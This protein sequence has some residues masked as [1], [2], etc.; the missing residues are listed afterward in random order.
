MR[1]RGNPITLILVVL[2]FATAVL[3]VSEA[4]GQADTL[5]VIQR[6]LLNIPA[7]VRPGDALSIQCQSSG[8][9]SGW[10]ATMLRGL[11]SL[12]MEILDASYSASTLWWTIQARV[13]NVSV[14]DLYDLVV[15]ASGGIADTSRHSVCVIPEFEEDYYFVHI[16]DT[17]LP[18]HRYYYEQGSETDSTELVD[19]REVINDINIINPAFVVLTG[20]LVNEGELED[21][22]GRRYFSRSQRLLRELKVPLY[23]T[24]GNHDVGGWIETPV[25]A[26]TARHTWWR[27]FGWPRLDDPPAGAFYHTQDY[28]FDY[29]PVHYVGLEAY[30]NYEYWR[31]EIYGSD[32]FTSEQMQW[33]ADNLAAASGSTSRVLFY[34]SDFQH[35]INLSSLG[36]ALALSGH[37][38]SNTNDTSP[39]YNVVTA[40]TCDGKRTYRLVRV[41]NGVVQP[42]MPVYAGSSGTSLNVAYSPDNDGTN[43][44]VTATITN[45]MSERFE[46]SMIRFIMPK[47]A[48]RAEVT[49]GTLVQVDR[50]GFY[51]TYYVAVDILAS[52]TQTVTLLL[53]TTDIE[54]PVVVL[55]TPN[56]SEVWEEGSSHEITWTATDNMEV[57][58]VGILLSLDGGLTFPDTLGWNV[59]NDGAFDWT[60][61]G[62]ASETARVKVIAF[63]GKGNTSNDASDADFEIAGST[64]GI[65]SRL[66]IESASPNP[67]SDHTAIRFGLPKP[68]FVRIDLYDVYGRFVRNIVKAEYPEGYQ[69]YEWANDG[70]IGG[71]VYFLR[72][73]LGEETATRKAVIPK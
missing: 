8:A 32:S 10:T 23:L 50:T 53:D 17:H 24:A 72:L 15:T 61:G 52:S 36:V 20:D 59:Y 19:L 37:T 6:P 45:T 65:P 25:P 22:L 56:G 35:Q 38:H 54:P 58:S 73:Q 4:A 34:H 26:G 33:L 47:E 39:P 57:T 67:F 3:R 12:P 18:T 63:D 64:A 46:H 68:G 71:G 44:S 28:S 27:F 41:S 49:G 2:L 66:V 43:Y 42:S 69:T 9:T 7:V 11:T 70:S 62:Q 40:A 16:T 60:V 13:P 29:G 51:A 5:T 30:N 14:H 55:T 21:Y 48:A 31:P 1:G